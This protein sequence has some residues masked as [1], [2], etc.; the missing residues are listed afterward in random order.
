M[1]TNDHVP[2]SAKVRIAPV[3][4]FYV[5]VANAGRLAQALETSVDF[6]PKALR[7]GGAILGNVE[8]DVGQVGSGFGGEKE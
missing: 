1:K 5:I 4:K 8:K 3:E 6:K 2:P 7:G